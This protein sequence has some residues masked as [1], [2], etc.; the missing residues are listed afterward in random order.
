[1]RLFSAWKVQCT[2]FMYYY[3]IV[4]YCFYW[5]YCQINNNLESLY[6]RNIFFVL[7]IWRL[8]QRCPRSRSFKDFRLRIRSWHVRNKIIV[9]FCQKNLEIFIKFRILMNVRLLSAFHNL[10]LFFF[11]QAKRM[12]DAGIPLPSHWYKISYFHCSLLGKNL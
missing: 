10:T 6:V 7:Q 1:M 8:S 5:A 12:A 3:I 2:V 9:F 11:F 4:M